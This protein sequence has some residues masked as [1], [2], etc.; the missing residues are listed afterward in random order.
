MKQQVSPFVFGR[1]A[2]GTTFTN[3][4][5]E[6]KRLQANF[7]N[8]I[9]TVLISP[10][11]WGKSSLVKKVAESI[12]EDNLK[13]IQLDAF[14]I[15]SE[16]DFYQT[17][18][19]E[20]IKATSTRFEEWIETAKQFLGHISPKLSLGSDPL[21]SFDISFQ[22]QGWE[23][24]YMDIL[25]LP[26]TIALEKN[27]RIVICIDEFQNISTFEDPLLFQKKLR[28]VW[29]KQ[30]QVAYCLYGS[31]QHMMTELFEKQSMP[32]YKFGE[33]MYLSKISLNDWVTFISERFEVSGKK[34][35][36]IHAQKIAETVQCQSYYVQQLAHLVWLQTKEEV[37]STI[38]ESALTD[39]LEQ[40]TLLYQR[41]TEGLT[42]YQ[43]NFL[44][45]LALGITTNLSSKENLKRFNIGTS[46][47]VNRIKEALINKEI[48]DCA[49]K[50]ITF[51]DPA[52][53]LWF[54]REM[55]S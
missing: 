35:S 20:V 21:N 39:L 5:K 33:V 26:E 40:N 3:R 29:Q 55:M 31:K 24:D 27:I 9:N 30:T 48:I 4:V 15:R 47:N 53:E 23:K 44:K 19:K 10:R 45:A 18:A 25:N 2:Q 36:F 22:W 6:R 46:A 52:Y 38:I 1:M 34:I 28:S 8:N 50:H 12:R 37:T 54:K 42:A 13:I 7:L 11:R 16:I 49:G 32:F 51:L 41:E 43:V 14:P 17:F